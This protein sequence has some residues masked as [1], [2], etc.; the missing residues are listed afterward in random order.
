MRKMLN[1]GFSSKALLEQEDIIHGYI[2]MFVKQLNTHATQKS[3]D[4]TQWYNF[5]SFDI[6]GD[7][8]FGEPFG[9]LKTRR[10]SSWFVG[11]GSG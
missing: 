4:M 11:G 6:V 10:L 2:D 8:S 1:N 3:A 7:L 5:A 9:S